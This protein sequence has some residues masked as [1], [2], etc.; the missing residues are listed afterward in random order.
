MSDKRGAAPALAAT[1]K[2]TDLAIVSL[3]CGRLEMC[4]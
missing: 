2:K 4:A 1:R 3:L